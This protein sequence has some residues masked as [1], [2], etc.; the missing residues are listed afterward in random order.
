MKRRILATALALC[1]TITLAGCGGKSDEV[2]EMGEKG[3]K[4]EDYVTLGE[5]KGIKA[6]KPESIEIT[7]EEVG[8]EIE[9]ELSEAAKT[10][11]ITDRAVQEGDTVNI[12]FSA[13]MDGEEYEDGNL[14]N[15]DLE[16]G[17]GD[18]IEGFE[19]GLV[20]ADIGEEVDLN[21]T[22]PDDYFDTEVAGKDVQFKVKINSISVVTVSELTEEYVK[23]NTDYQTVEEYKESIRKSLEEDNEQNI[24]EQLQ[25]DVFEQV[26]ANAT[27]DGYPEE[28]YDDFYA[29]VESS[30]QSTADMLGIELEEVYSDFYGITEED[31]KEQT[32]EEIQQYLIWQMIAQNE[33]IQL[34]QDEYDRGIKELLEYYEEDSVESFEE[35]YGKEEIAE[36][37]LRQKVM[38]F[39]VSKAEVTE[40]SAEE[41]NSDEDFDLEE[42]EEADDD[43]A[44]ID[45]EAEEKMLQ[46]EESGADEID[47]NDIQ[48]VE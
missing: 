26:V 37:L 24:Q 39:L 33:N 16:I 15:Y 17:S 36:E 47:E 19:S 31:L 22:F 30:Y 42:I 28:L 35:L 21:L 48:K 2:V 11:E 4:L 23:A 9:Y 7:D 32:I 27:V 6:T 3:Y 14:D 41:Y 20:G 45:Q 18:F 12:D 29:M 13:T 38:E 25:A 43:T 40:V 46:E 34:T 5:Y 8:Y 44:E 1:T 10:E